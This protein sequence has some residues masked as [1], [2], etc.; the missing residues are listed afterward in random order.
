M[1]FTFFQINI[2]S[3]CLESS[4]LVPNLH[5]TFPLSQ[6]SN[7]NNANSYNIFLLLE[8]SWPLLALF[9]SGILLWAYFFFLLLLL[10]G[11]CYF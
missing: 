4:N 11:K 3:Q 8:E 5:I 6:G 2:I 1:L 9:C 7:N 10:S